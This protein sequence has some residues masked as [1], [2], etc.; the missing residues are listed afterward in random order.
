MGRK[1]FY[2]MSRLI[3]V[4]KLLHFEFFV[5][6]VDNL[7]KNWTK[8]KF[9]VSLYWTIDVLQFMFTLAKIVTR[10]LQHIVGKQSM[11]S[12]GL[13]C[14]Y[15]KLVMIFWVSLYMNCMSLNGWP[16]SPNTKKLT[17]FLWR[18]I[19][20]YYIKSDIWANTLNILTEKCQNME[21]NI[22]MNFRIKS[23]L[24]QW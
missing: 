7:Y 19:L 1:A 20:Y 5:I 4:Q 24:W 8:F 18:H 3:F 9:Q 14:D 23:F 22:S 6:F 21:A 12:K 17:S 13:P 15:H 11:K 10:S 2:R 16:I